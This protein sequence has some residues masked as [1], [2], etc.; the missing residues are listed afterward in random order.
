VLAGVLALITIIAV[1]L[2][3]SHRRKLAAFGIFWFLICLLPVSNIIPLEAHLAERFL[4]FPLIGFALALADTA[5][6]RRLPV[7]M[8]LTVLL[9]AYGW[10]SVERNR[11][12]RNDFT[13]WS[14]AVR[15]SPESPR[16][17]YALGD[18]YYQQ[19]KFREAIDQYRQALELNPNVAELYNALGLAWEGLGDYR[20]SIAVYQEGLKVPSLENRAKISL[21]INLGNANGRLHN[22]KEAAAYYHKILDL[23]PDDPEARHNLAVIGRLSKNAVH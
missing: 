10:R 2:A 18:I 19:G 16:V 21:M 3:V 12:W 8:L 20:H 4:Y 14:S 1:A 11:D 6:S 22:Y 7:L 17:H 23:E 9:L 13:L 5:R 15:T